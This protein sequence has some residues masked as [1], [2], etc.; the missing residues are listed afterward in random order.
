M[1]DAVDMREA[2]GGRGRDCDGRMQAWR[3]SSS[4]GLGVLPLECFLIDRKIFAP[5]NGNDFDQDL[6]VDDP[7]HETDRLLRCVEFVVAGEIKA[8]PV[9]KMLAEPWGGFEF[10]EL[11][12]NRCF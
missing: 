1:R 5:A 4:I 6:L 10:S 7:V 9:A 11:L 2:V 12:R 8:G 3:N